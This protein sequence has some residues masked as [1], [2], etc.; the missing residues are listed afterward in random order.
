MND[1]MNI[2]NDKLLRYIKCPLFYHKYNCSE[3]ISEMR[4]IIHV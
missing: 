3:V 2:E 4:I 1:N